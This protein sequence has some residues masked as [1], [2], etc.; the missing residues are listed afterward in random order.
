ML[1]VVTLLSLIHSLQVTMKCVERYQKGTSDG[2]Y[3]SARAHGRFTGN[4]QPETMSRSLDRVYVDGI[5]VTLGSPRKHLWTYAIGLSDDG[6]FPAFNCP[7]AKYPGPEPPSFVHN[8]YYCESGSTGTVLNGA[9]VYTEDP[10]WDGAGCLPENSC[11]YQPSMPW[12]YRQLPKPEY[13]SIEVRMCRDQHF[14]DED[15]MV[16]QM[17]LYIH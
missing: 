10:L 16:E 3:P 4:Y 11:C 5:S 9:R 6:D 7:C 1:P 17:E 2:F 15:L 8:D 14:N 12:F 13:G